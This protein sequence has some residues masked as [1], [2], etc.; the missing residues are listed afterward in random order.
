MKDIISWHQ[1]EKNSFSKEISFELFCFQI[2]NKKLG[3][4]GLDRFEG[5]KKSIN[6]KPNLKY[7]IICTPGKFINNKPHYPWDTLKD[8]IK[9][10]N[11]NVNLEHW[12]RDKFETFFHSDREGYY[13]IFNYYFNT[14]FI[15]VKFIND[16]SH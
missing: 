9:K 6:D 5:F 1:L 10:I 12:H 13:S 2:A 3:E 14:K 7:W 8:S 16:F 11:S 4:Y 15:G